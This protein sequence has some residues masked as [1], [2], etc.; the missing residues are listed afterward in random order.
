MLFDGLVP[1]V[2]G[3]S[4]PNGCFADRGMMTPFLP[5]VLMLLVFELGSSF[6]VRVDGHQLILIAAILVLTIR[7]G[8]R[9]CASAP[10][11]I[12][13][14]YSTPALDFSGIRTPLLRAVYRDSESL[15]NTFP[16]RTLF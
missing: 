6:T 11:P 5:D 4:G 13:S 16:Q 2:D 8:F 14:R 10:P 1:S 15:T 12:R 7:R 9:D 3:A